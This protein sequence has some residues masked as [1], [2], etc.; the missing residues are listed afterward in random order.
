MIQF[1]SFTVDVFL[2]EYWQKKPVVLRQALAH[3]SSV[4]SADELAGLALEEDVESRLVIETP[5]KAPYWHLKKGPFDEAMFTSLPK[6]HWTLL[7]QGVDRLVPEVMCLLDHFNFIPAWRL[8]DVMISYAVKEG[9]VGPHFDHYDVFLLQASGQR[10]W[11]LTTKD[12]NVNNYLTDVDLRIMAKF[13]A[14]EEYILEPGDILYLP[15]HVGHHGVSLSNDCMTYSFG[16]RSYR[17]LELWND[18]GDFMAEATLDGPICSDPDWSNLANCADISV[19]ALTK[20]RQCLQHLINDEQAL[21][22]W[23]GMY[24]TQ[25]DRFA[26]QTMPLPDDEQDVIDCKTFAHELSASE[27]LIRD[28]FCRMAISQADHHLFINGQLWDTAQ[29]SWPLVCY[30][31]THRVLELNLLKSLIQH[32]QDQQF[33]YEL[34]KSQYLQWN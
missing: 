25:P 22:K 1:N 23:F 17:A 33:I 18:F 9:S 28:G 24:V 32:D 16:Y 19:D 11:S 31:A 7:V 12:C 4:L 29:V 2:Q 13:D 34:W 8:D 14:E 6:T 21:K 27:G 15:P 20:V 3:F 26:Q 5:T 10:R 30:I